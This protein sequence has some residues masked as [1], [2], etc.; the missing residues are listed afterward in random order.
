MQKPLCLLPHA[1]SKF[2]AA[3]KHKPKLQDTSRFAGFG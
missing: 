2:I 1:P 3:L